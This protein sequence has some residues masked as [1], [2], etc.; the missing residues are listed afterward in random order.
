M[1][2]TERLLEDFVRDAAELPEI[3]EAFAAQIEVRFS[4]DRSCPSRPQ[5]SGHRRVRK[6]YLPDDDRGPTV[7]LQRVSVRLGLAEIPAPV[8]DFTSR[9]VD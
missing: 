6:P 3:G 8:K 1:D 5:R 2:A 9:L 4:L 7:R